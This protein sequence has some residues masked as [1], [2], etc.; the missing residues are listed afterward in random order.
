MYVEDRGLVFNQLGS[1]FGLGAL[2]EHPAVGRLQRYLNN[3]AARAGFAPLS[4]DN[5]YGGCTHAALKK[6]GKWY[7]ALPGSTLVYAT[8]AG[9]DAAGPMVMGAFLAGVPP[10][11][12][13]TPVEVIECQTAFGEWVA[14]GRPAC[15]AG[16]DGSG[17]GD[18]VKDDGDVVTDDIPPP[19]PPKKAGL[20]TLGWV[21]IGLGVVVAGGVVYYVATQKPATGRV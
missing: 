21:L 20:G 5:K 2:T 18:I 11:A 14:E 3:F 6:F 4:I 7:A 13:L 16:V 9:V 15:G 8:D 19:P 10:Y 1:F 12:G 17:G